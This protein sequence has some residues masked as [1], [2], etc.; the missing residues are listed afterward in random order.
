MSCRDQN[1]L[2]VRATAYLVNITD[3]TKSEHEKLTSFHLAF[4]VR[5]RR[6]RERKTYIDT[7]GVATP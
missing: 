3:Q 1:A 5:R 2:V 7:R 4:T 6:F